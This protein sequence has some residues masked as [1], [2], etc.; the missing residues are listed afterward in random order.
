MSGKDSDAKILKWRGNKVYRC[1][2]CGYDT[3]SK[4]QFEDHIV[5]AHAPLRVIEGGKSQAP[6]EPVEVKE[7]NDGNASS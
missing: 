1:R 7:S 4:E 3:F 5:R 6:A 2:M